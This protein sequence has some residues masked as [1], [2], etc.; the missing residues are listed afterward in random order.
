MGKKNSSLFKWK[1]TPFSKDNYKIAKIHWQNLQIF[2]RTIGPISTKLGT[3]HPYVKQIQVFWNE[4]PSPFPKGDN[5]KI[6][7]IHWW[8]LTSFPEPLYQFQTNL[9]QSI[10]GWK[11]FKFVQMKGNE[12]NYL[13]KTLNVALQVDSDWDGQ[14][15][16]WL[17]IPKACEFQAIPSLQEVHQTAYGLHYN[18]K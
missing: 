11:G 8:N 3:K 14:A 2:Y 1:A 4:G 9:A 13:V 12:M 18:E 6:A 15:W 17:A 10:L 7:K 16:W 5:D